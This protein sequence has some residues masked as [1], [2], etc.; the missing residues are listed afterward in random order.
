MTRTLSCKK[1]VGEG[2]FSDLPEASCKDA[3]KP[4]VTEACNVDIVCKGE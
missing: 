1:Q 2:E 4:P 3:I